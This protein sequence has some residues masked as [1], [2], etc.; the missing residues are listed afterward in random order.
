[1]L[2]PFRELLIIIITIIKYFPAL[3]GEQMMF[4]NRELELAQL[5]RLYKSGQAELFVLYGRRRVRKTELLRAF[6]EG[7]SRHGLS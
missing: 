7:K 2:K 4:I 5:D 1:M 3:A 6:S